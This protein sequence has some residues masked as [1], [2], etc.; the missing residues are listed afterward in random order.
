MKTRIAFVGVGFVAQTVHLPAAFHNEDCEIVG[1]A[2][3]CLDLALGIAKQYGVS[4]VF[5]D[6]I[7]LLKNCAFDC[8][9]VTVKRENTFFIVCDL[10]SAGKHVLAEKP[11]SLNSSD[12]LDLVKLSIEKRSIV[13]T[14]YMKTFDS[15]FLKF[16]QEVQSRSCKNIKQIR[17]FCYMGQSYANIYDSTKS[18]SFKQSPSPTQFFP[19]SIRPH[20]HNAYEQFLNVFSHMTHL[21]EFLLDSD[22]ILQ[23]ADLEESGECVAF[24]LLDSHPIVLQYVRG[25]QFMWNEGIDVIY[26]DEMIDLRLPAAFHS[27]TPGTVRIR[28]GLDS[29]HESVLTPGWSSAFKS[30]MDAFIRDVSR[31]Y[32]NDDTSYLDRAVKQVIFA[33][34]LFSRFSHV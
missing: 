7:E 26:Q 15:A 22:L 19:E 17:A 21:V 4:Q 20:Q 11:I 12:G 3:P 8:A 10:V 34:D 2:D 28:S 24:G 13:R 23:H 31:G 29:N 5:S 30:Q 32:Q 14:G 25:K 9:V 6:H 33:E 27:N 18:S 1:I 16:Q